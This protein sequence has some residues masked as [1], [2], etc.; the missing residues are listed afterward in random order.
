MNNKISVILST[1]NEEQFIEKTINEIFNLDI[2][3]EVIVVD[4]N[5][6]DQTQKIVKSISNSN[7]RLIPRKSRGLAAACMVGLIYSKSDIVCWIKENVK[8]R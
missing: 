5:S 3:A 1:Y 2:D 6:K 4:D 7:L 8:V